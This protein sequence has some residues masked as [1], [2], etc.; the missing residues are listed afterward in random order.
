DIDNRR[1]DDNNDKNTG[2]REEEA[3][4]IANDNHYDEQDD[5]KKHGFY[6]DGDLHEILSLS[7]VLFLKENE[8][9]DEQINHS[10]ASLFNFS[11][12]K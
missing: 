5:N 9:S 4:S 12:Y 6:V 7:G 2:S 8:Y 10:G 1:S 3:D 11:L